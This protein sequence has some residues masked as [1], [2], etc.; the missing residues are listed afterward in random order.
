MARQEMT[1]VLFDIDGTLLDAQGAGRASFVSSLSTV[2]GLNDTL[3]HVR[4]EGAT[5]LDILRKI[6]A[7]HGR[8]ITAED[9]ARFFEQLPTELEKH[10]LK[11]ACVLHPGVKELL[12]TLAQDPRFILGLVTGNIQA[13]AEVKL[14]RFDL[15]HHF[16][17]GAYGHEHSVRSRIAVLAMQRARHKLIHGQK[18]GP[19]FLVG[20]TPSDISAASA[21]GAYSVGVTTGR[22]T[23][24]QLSQ[25]GA[26]FVFDNLS[27]V[28][29]VLK[30]LGLPRS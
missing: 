9:E 12:E 20:D 27:D 28:S 24:E 21:I 1:L 11:M 6:M 2:F 15:Q 14:R 22:H 25:F 7:R 4:F 16:K 30:T 13:C 10:A 17:L 26:D 5:D 8:S 3:E 23:R 18:L 19:R 29:S